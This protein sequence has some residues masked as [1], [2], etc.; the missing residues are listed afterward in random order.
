LY[1]TSIFIIVILFL[2]GC[3]GKDEEGHLIKE[4]NF[5]LDTSQIQEVQII[6]PDLANLPNENILVTFSD[7]KQFDT[8]KQILNTSIYKD[9]EFEDIL[10]DYEI[11]VIVKDG[12]S[13]TI[14]YWVKLKRFEDETAKNFIIDSETSKKMNSFLQTLGLH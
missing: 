11:K 8:L 13:Y 3:Q 2:V 5:S 9:Q 4:N 12:S 6:K 10:H 14:R 1:K 7:K